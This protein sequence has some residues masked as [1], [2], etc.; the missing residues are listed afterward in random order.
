[1][2]LAARASVIIVAV[3]M[4]ATV[5]A[6]PQETAV[7]FEVASVKPNVGSDLSIPYRLPPPDG[8]TLTNNPLDSIVY[9]AYEMQPFRVVGMP[10]WTRE[11]RFDIAAKASGPI[12]D[13]QL[14]LKLEPQRRPSTCSSST[15]STVQHQIETE[16]SRC[17]HTVLR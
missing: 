3:M 7:R 15:A 6:L 9:N 8:I 11:A 2:L 10:A 17:R 12:S 13:T 1:M 4:S 5:A 14:G 16:V